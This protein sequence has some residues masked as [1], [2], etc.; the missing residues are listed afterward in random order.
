MTSTNR[1][2]E[3][4]RLSAREDHLAK[5]A[6]FRQGGLDGIDAVKESM[7]AMYWPPGKTV[8][9]EDARRVVNAVADRHGDRI[10]HGVAKYALSPAYANG[11][12]AAV[13]TYQVEAVRQGTATHEDLIAT[14]QS[15][16]D[17][18]VASEERPTD[19]LKPL[20]GIGF[21]EHFIEAKGLKAV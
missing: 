3:K 17:T 13:K 21:Q 4:E 2:T 1:M 9:A 10:S 19:W 20:E 5:M 15:R 7:T 14:V 11:F 18:Y 6:Y 8:Q 12:G 16:L